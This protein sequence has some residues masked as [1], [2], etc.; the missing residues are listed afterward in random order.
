MIHHQVPATATKLSKN[1]AAMLSTGYCC[2]LTIFLIK[3]GFICMDMF[4]LKIIGTGV[5]LIH[6]VPF[7]DVKVQMWYKNNAK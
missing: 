4:P 2:V 7:H 1:R 5:L 6:T 3:H